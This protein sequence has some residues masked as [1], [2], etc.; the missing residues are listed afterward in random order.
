MGG[1][2]ERRQLILDSIF[3][4]GLVKV[5]V[6]AERFGVTQTTI[7]KDL[8]YLESKWFAAPVVWKRDA[9]FRS[10]KGHQPWKEKVDKLRCQASDRKGCR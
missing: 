6:L 10:D 4:Q 2:R 8:N 3:D 1:I 7:R 9:V 5:S